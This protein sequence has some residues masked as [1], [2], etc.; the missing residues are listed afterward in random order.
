MMPILVQ[1]FFQGDSWT[2]FVIARWVPG[3]NNKGTLNY[4]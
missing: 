4:R 3:D 2:L 1:D